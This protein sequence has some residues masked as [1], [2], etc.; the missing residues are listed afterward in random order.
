MFE[1]RKAVPEDALG[2]TIVNVYTWKTTY[3][4]LMSDAAIDSRI[5]GLPEKAEQC[6]ADIE[7][8]DNFF[9]AAVGR[10]VIGFCCYGSSR[11]PAYPNSG[12]IYGLYSL[13]GYQGLG[14][15]KAL[16]SAGA[17]ALSAE[18]FSS[19]I[20]NCLRGNPSLSFYQH[21]GGK[22]VSRREDDL[23]G[24][25]ITEDILYFETET[26]RPIHPANIRSL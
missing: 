14:I 17:S 6:R 1:I 18:G 7:Q 2:I 25:R 3:S 26:G 24:M 21:M 19:M 16:F 22:I 20:I 15:G 12:E 9:V 4:G 23:Y 13:K 11:N 10:T 5:A 8:N